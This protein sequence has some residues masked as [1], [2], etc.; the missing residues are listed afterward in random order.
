MVGNIAVAVV[1]QFVL[2]RSLCA[3]SMAHL[4]LGG[5]WRANSKLKFSI[6]GGV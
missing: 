4:Q 1:M 5:L 3:M 6:L 2:R